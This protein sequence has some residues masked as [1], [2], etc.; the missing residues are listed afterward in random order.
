MYTAL[1]ERWQAER[2]ALEL[3]PL[4]DS[5]LQNLR[6]YIEQVLDRTQSEELTALQRQL[7]ETELTNLQFMMKSL[8]QIRVKKILTHLL[9]QEIDYDL[10]TRSERRFADQI[11]RNLRSVLLPVNDLFTRLEEEGS[12]R[13]LLV[14]FLEDH[15]QLIGVDLKTYGP[16]RAD[17]LATLPAEN[18]RLIIRKNQAEPVSIGE[19]HRESP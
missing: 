4:R 15:P 1:L 16:F 18:A 9:D 11:S 10:L 3:L 7:L 8:L 5:F 2:D 14:R 12:S 17:D 6:E 13:L 19:I